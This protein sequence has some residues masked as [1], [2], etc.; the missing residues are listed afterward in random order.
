M[1]Q[2]DRTLADLVTPEVVAAAVAQVPVE[3]LTDEDSFGGIEPLQEAYAS[4]LLRRLEARTQWLP[5]LIAD[6]D[7]AD[8]HEASRT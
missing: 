8:K 4:Q 5:A 2:A 3:W 6:L 7:H 1:A